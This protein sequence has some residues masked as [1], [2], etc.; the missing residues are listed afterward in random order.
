L[1]ALQG[2]PEKASILVLILIPELCMLW[3]IVVRLKAGAGSSS[4]FTSPMP[5][6]NPSRFASGLYAPGA[7]VKA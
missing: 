3:Y 1:T 7:A 6:Q 4:G 2:W 5:W